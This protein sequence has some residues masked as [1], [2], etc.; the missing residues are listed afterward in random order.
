MQRKSRTI[1]L[2]LL[3]GLPKS[4]RTGEFSE[5]LAKAIE[6][7]I[8][9]LTDAKTELDDLQKVGVY[10]LVGSNIERPEHRKAYVGKADI[11]FARLNRHKSENDQNFW[12][13]TCVLVSKDDNFSTSHALYLE[14][15]L[16]KMIKELPG[17]ELSNV[18][19][20]SENP[21]KLSKRH[22]SMV[23]QRL[24]DAI[25][26][27]DAMGSSVFRDLADHQNKIQNS[28][29]PTTKNNTGK[30]TRK[31]K[32]TPNGNSNVMHEKKVKRKEE[33]IY[34]SKGK[35]HNAYMSI[36]KENKVIIH[37]DSMVTAVTKRQHTKLLKK[38]KRF[39]DELVRKGILE[40]EDD[41]Y[42]VIRDITLESLSESTVF[43][44][45]Y[46]S[47]S[48]L[49]WKYYD[50]T[51]NRVISLGENKKDNSVNR[52]LFKFDNKKIKA[53]ILIDRENNKYTVL[54]NSI[55]N[56]ELGRNV[57]D[58]LKYLRERLEKEGVLKREENHLVFQKDYEFETPNEAADV[59][60]GYNYYIQKRLKLDDGTTY[61]EWKSDRGKKQ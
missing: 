39:K 28:V 22:R 10:V 42:R 50:K 30:S 15:L 26:I 44:S 61:G 32:K 25:I 51:N 13:D 5:G 33:V 19:R 11:M 46:R 12:Q 49:F 31:S 59:V 56:K 40:K 55:A 35:N 37:R 48:Y 14:G 45:G 54:K 60:V 27:F 4:L 43:V 21:G 16:I 18:N 23:E 52:A 20:P 24:E 41:M 3:Y 38:V 7:S 36:N 53:E 8:E 34:Q 17:W 58:K 1:E 6:F 47:N 29:K 9:E 57:S 2:D